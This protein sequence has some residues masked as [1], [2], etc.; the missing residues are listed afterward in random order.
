MAQDVLGDVTKQL[1]TLFASKEELQENVC[2]I[3]S[4]QLLTREK[5]IIKVADVCVKIEADEVEKADLPTIDE[6][7]DTDDNDDD[8]DPLKDNSY[9]EISLLQRTGPIKAKPT[10]TYTKQ[11]DGSGSDDDDF[12]DF[13][14]PM[15][16][17][18]QLQKKQGQSQALK[19]Q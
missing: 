10:Q 12:E 2:G 3:C 19:T 14:W 4:K 8:Y 1:Q 5:K 18:G 6:E 17:K 15:W 11:E 16:Q 13:W 9:V 7:R